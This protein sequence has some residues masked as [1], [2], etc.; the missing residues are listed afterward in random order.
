MRA[1][2]TFLLIHLCASQISSNLFKN[3]ITNNLVLNCGLYN[4]MAK[5]AGTAEYT[6]CNEC[7]VYDTKQ[8]DD[9]APVMQVLRECGVPLYCYQ[10][11]IYTSPEW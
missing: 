1:E 8:S 6:D 11:L 4:N 5:A 10:S 9:E 2:G 3:E 7:P